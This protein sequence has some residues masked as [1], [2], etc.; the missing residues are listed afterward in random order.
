MCE[1]IYPLKL[2]VSIKTAAERLAKTDGVSLNQFI[3]TAVAEKIDA[4]KTVDAMLALQAEKPVPADMMIFLKNAPDVE[5][6]S[7]DGLGTG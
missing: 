4:L 2:P 3:V 6:V 7:G 5:P 1:S